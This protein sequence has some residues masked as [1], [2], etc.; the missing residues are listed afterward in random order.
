[1]HRAYFATHRFIRLSRRDWKGRAWRMMFCL[2][3]IGW[4]DAAVPVSNSPVWAGEWRETQR[5]A[6]PEAF[7]AAAADER[8]A[9]AIAN[10]VIARYD[11]RTGEK[12]AASHGPAEHLNSGFFHEGKL[13][14]A[15]SNYPK[16]PEQSEVK[17]LDPETME[18][19]VHHSFGDSPHGSLTVVIRHAEDWWCV[20]ARYGEENHQTVMVRYDNHWKEL[21]VWTFPES[22]VSRLGR[23]S[24]S[25]GFWR[26]EKFL[27]TGHDDKLLFVLQLPASGT[28]LEHLDTVPA[29]FTGQGIA[30]DPATGGLV[31]I[32][33]PER[34]ILFAEWKDE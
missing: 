25:G 19:T 27:A 6:A 3:M 24:I 32:H 17:V 7:Q 14:C 22:V 1:M 13:Y 34:Q 15:H 26:E 30:P 5:L 8:Y 18:L 31:G 23:Y 29:P 10:R 16:R 9:Y 28:V 12:L 2:L 20:F 33:R 11:R 4:L 21:G